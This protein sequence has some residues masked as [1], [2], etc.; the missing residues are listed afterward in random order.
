MELREIVRT[1]YGVERPQG[2][3]EEEIAAVRERFGVLP[4]V[5][6]EFWRGF[7]RTRELGQCQDDW[8][9]PEQYAKWKWLEEYD[10]LVLLNENQGCCRAC[11]RRE[12]LTLPDPPVYTRM[13][14]DDPWLLSAP[15]TSAFLQAALLYESVWRLE[16]APDEFYWLTD[17]ELAL[18]QSKLT[19]HPAVLRNWMEMEITCYHNRP[20]NLLAILDVG[21]QYQ[22][23]YGGAT[24]ASCAALL[25]VMEGLGEAI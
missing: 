17:E 4:A 19:R 25:E 24:E 23:L 14:E 22:T 1:L 18:V 20:D 11:V 2:C 3:T 12:D 21:G 13:E 8:M 5:V 16:Y 10:S 9:F 15:T 6:E 7:G